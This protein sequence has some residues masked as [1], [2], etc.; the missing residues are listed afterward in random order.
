MSNAIQAREDYDLRLNPSNRAV[1]VLQRQCLDTAELLSHVDHARGAINGRNAACIRS[2]LTGLRGELTAGA[3]LL[4][5]TLS[6]RR[7]R[8]FRAR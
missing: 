7:R 8:L 2:L 3:K 6:H 1:A 4:E 5:A